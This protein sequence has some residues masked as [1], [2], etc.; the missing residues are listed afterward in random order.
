MEAQVQ[1][2]AFHDVLTDLP[3]RRLLIDRLSRAVA[4]SRRSRRHGAVLFLDLDNLKALNDTHGHEMGDVLLIAVADRL[5]SCIR[6]MDT[7]A[8]FGGDEFVII[9][10]ELEVD[11]AESSLQ[12][13]VVAEKIRG[14]LAEPYVLRIEH[15]NGVETTLEH[16]CT[17]SI[18]V[19]L[20][21]DHDVDEDE[22]LK[23]ADQAMYQAK[24]A[25]RNSIRFY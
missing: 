8:R 16:N 6:D 1:Q 12:A 20:F 17:A 14:V 21:A 7:A 3:N 25:G 5:K 13:A 18:G 2:L 19:A 15:E 9:V 22:I 4:A 23:R 10:G 24:Q 11:E